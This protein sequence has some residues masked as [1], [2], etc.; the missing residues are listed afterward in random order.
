MS[1]LRG[2]TSYGSLVTQSLPSVR[3]WLLAMLIIWQCLLVPKSHTTPKASPSK[4]DL[5]E[6]GTTIFLSI[7]LVW[8]DYLSTAFIVRIT[9]ITQCGL[10]SVMI[11]AERKNDYPRLG[12]KEKRVEKTIIWSDSKSSLCHSLCILLH[13]LL[14]PSPWYSLLKDMTI[15]LVAPMLSTDTESLLLVHENFSIALRLCLY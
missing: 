2:T 4:V 6:R 12:R 1:V 7:G 15:H 3:Q 14:P 5:Y 13:S 11:P 10:R 9:L 8:G